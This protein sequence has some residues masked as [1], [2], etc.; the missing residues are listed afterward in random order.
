M[1]IRDDSGNQLATDNPPL[2]ANGDFAGN[3]GHPPYAGGSPVSDDGEYSRHGRVRRTRGRSPRHQGHPHSAGA[4]LHIATCVGEVTHI[5]AIPDPFGATPYQ[6][7]ILA[8]SM[9]GL[10]NVMI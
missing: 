10:A 2:A 1:V 7:E 4:H 6:P 5:K 8:G 3:L 9:E